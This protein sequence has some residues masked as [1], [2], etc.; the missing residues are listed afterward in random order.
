MASTALA[1]MIAAHCDLEDLLQL[2]T[3]KKLESY[4][5]T[6]CGIGDLNAEFQ[7][8]IHQSH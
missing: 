3:G 7:K 4:L 6:T 2:A 8:W 5:A 1:E